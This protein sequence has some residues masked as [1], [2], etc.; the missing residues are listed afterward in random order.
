M[1]PVDQLIALQ[2]GKSRFIQRIQ[3]GIASV[4]AGLEEHSHGGR[5]ARP[6]RAVQRRRAVLAS[7]VD[8]RH[9][10]DRGQ[11]Q[12]HYVAKF[13]FKTL[14]EQRRHGGG[15]ECE[16]KNR[17]IHSILLLVDRGFPLPLDPCKGEKF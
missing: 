11:L 1:G 8:L 14:R 16:H 9:A 10:L 3:V 5:A 17:P 6:H 15:N 4:T 7:H 13:D 12:I 2:V